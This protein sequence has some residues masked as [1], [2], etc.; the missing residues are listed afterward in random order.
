M[1][2]K[3]ICGYCGELEAPANRTICDACA[4]KYSTIRCYIQKNPQSTLMEISSSTG[5]S[6]MKIKTFIDRGHFSLKM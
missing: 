1:N 6:L 4:E 2:H 5:I 3:T